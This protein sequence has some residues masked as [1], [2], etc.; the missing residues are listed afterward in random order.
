MRFFAA[1]VYRPADLGCRPSPLASAASAP[2]GQPTIAHRFNGG[3]G[4]AVLSQSPAGATETTQFGCVL[5][6]VSSESATKRRPHPTPFKVQDEGWQRQAEP[7]ELADG[8][9]AV[10]ESHRQAGACRCHP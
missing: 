10:S 7:A 9:F 5:P 4:S 8:F 6:P 2:Q 3:Y 1:C